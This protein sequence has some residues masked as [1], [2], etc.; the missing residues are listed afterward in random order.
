TTSTT[1]RDTLAPSVPTAL[2]AS[3]ASC[4]QINLGWNPSTDS[5]GS[6][7]KGYNVYR[8]S[9]LVKQVLAPGTT[10][11][12]PGMA[13][14]TVYTYNVAAI[15]NA[16]DTSG[17]SVAA[18]TNTPACVAGGQFIWNR[19]FGGSGVFDAAHAMAVATD[20]SG[21]VVVAG[22][23]EGTVNFGT[24]PMTSS[25]F[26]DVFVAKYSAAGV[27]LWAKSYGEPNDDEEALG[28]AMDGSGNV[29]VTG[30][31][32]QTVNFGTGPLTAAGTYLG[33]VFV[34]KYSASGAPLWVKQVGSTGFDKGT[35]V[36][37]DS[38]SNVLV[39][40]YFNGTVNFGLGTVTS[41]GGPDA[42]VVKY[43]PQGAPLWAKRLGGSGYDVGHGIAVDG[44]GNVTVTGAFQNTADS[45]TGLLTSAGDNDVF[46]AKYSPGGV[47]LWS[48][49]FGGA[50]EDGAT[51]VAFDGSGNVIV[52]GSFTGA[53][54]FG[55]GLLPDLGGG[56]IFLAKYSPSGAHLWSK[57]FGGA[58]SLGEQAA[59]VTADGAGNVIL[60]G[61]ILDSVS[62]GGPVL[63]SDQT[64]DIYVAKFTAA[65]AYLWSRRAGE[66][67]DDS[68][69]AV[70]ADGSGNAL[71]AGYFSVAADLGGGR[72]TSPGGTDGFVVKYAP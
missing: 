66:G 35:A 57:R 63:W 17:M 18:S 68:G 26:K 51:S 16:G 15:D 9:V 31:F 49:R 48:K 33:D 55:G 41:A 36:A 59:G 65:G 14:S 69:L 19:Q 2:N 56:D 29:I 40:G 67:Y 70:A 5:G 61:A 32:K 24:G 50:G 23:F 52:T 45:G 34:A 62:F 72:L 30:Y 43:T 27:P 6:G 42:F 47:P 37:V 10:T 64:Y 46:L 58:G 3:A 21:N 22:S 44:G 20:P 1:L 8:N 11:S 12:D 39:T 53:V 28:V 25:G 54:D 60:T 7:L 13:A 38:A 71:V 4:N